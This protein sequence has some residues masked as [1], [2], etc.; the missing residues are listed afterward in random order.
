MEILSDALSCRWG[1]FVNYLAAALAGGLGMYVVTFLAVPIGAILRVRNAFKTDDAID[2][3]FDIKTDGL[4][5]DSRNIMHVSDQ[6]SIMSQQ[7]R[8]I[9]SKKGFIQL[10]TVGAVFFVIVGSVGGAIC[11]TPYAP[12][13]PS[14]GMTESTNTDLNASADSSSGQGALPGL[15]QGDQKTLLATVSVKKINVRKNDNTDALVVSKLIAGDVIVLDARN[16]S[17]TWAHTT[18]QGYEGWIRL[19]LLTISEGSPDELPLR[20]E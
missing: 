16:A 3:F 8:W 11:T 17:T 19:D 13:K 15:D 5:R 6:P 10:F 14:M 4:F 9:L 20:E 1:I 18:M 7:Y 2:R 12:P